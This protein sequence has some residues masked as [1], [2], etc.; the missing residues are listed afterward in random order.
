LSE[1]SDYPKEYEPQGHRREPISPSI[2]ESQLPILIG[3]FDMSSNR[4]VSSCKHKAM[5]NE[6]GSIA[7][8]HIDRVAVVFS[9][10]AD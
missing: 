9:E 7:L 5:D 4:H 1:V 6:K 3:R 10:T 2:L 8:T